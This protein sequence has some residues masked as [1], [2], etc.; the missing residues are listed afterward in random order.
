MA[1]PDARHAKLPKK[2]LKQ[3]DH[4]KGKP[5]PHDRVF[6][7][8]E[9]HQMGDGKKKKGKKEA[10]LVLRIERKLRDEFIAIC[11]ETDTSAAREVRK[12]IKRFIKRYEAGELD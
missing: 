1:R 5:G 4:G 8:S 6:S 11:Q 2:L 9:N 7:I 12:F 10:Q 3:L